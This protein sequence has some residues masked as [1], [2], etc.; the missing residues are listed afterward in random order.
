MADTKLRD[1]GSNP[2]RR[3][4]AE[5]ALRAR[6]SCSRQDGYEVGTSPTNGATALVEIAGDRPPIPVV[7]DLKMPR[8][9]GVELLKRLR[10]RG[11][12]ISR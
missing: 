12:S 6:K 4:R 8:M 11:A 1:Q 7:T 10:A 9:D 5:R 2:R 3:R